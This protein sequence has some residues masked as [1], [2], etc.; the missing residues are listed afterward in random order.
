MSRCSCHPSLQRFQMTMYL[1]GFEF[2]I[3]GEGV[4]ELM[5]GARPPCLLPQYPRG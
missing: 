2:G 5:I 1:P 3:G 4:G